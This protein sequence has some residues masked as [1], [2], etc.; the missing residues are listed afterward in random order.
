MNN[1]ELALELMLV[2]LPTVFFV[3]IIII[4]FGKL[5]IALVNK[6]LPEE[7]KPLTTKTSSSGIDAKKMT[8]IEKAVSVI[9]NGKGSVTN[10][11]K[12]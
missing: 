3:L 12:L 2:G 1:F 5:L 7:V 11:E 10:V 4:Y 9:T 8:V 6:Y